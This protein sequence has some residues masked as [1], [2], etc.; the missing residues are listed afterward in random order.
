MPLEREQVLPAGQVPEPDG[1]VMARGDEPA[2][3][4]A[5]RHAVDPA[6]CPLSVRSSWP[7]AVSQSITVLS[8]VTRPRCV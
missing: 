7:V 3:V 4:G 8:L 6:V 2:A 5:E 1:L